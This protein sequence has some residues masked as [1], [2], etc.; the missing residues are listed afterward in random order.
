[1]STFC[2]RGAMPRRVHINLRAVRAWRFQNPDENRKESN[3]VVKYKQSSEN[4]R[5]QYK[6]E[7]SRE[8][9]DTEKREKTGRALSL[10]AETIV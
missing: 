1:M 5:R 4:G 3:H 6:L 8:G 7:V 2:A 10:L 9:D